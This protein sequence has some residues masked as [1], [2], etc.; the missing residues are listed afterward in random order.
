M[1]EIYETFGSLTGFDAED[2]T[3]RRE[4]TYVVVGTDDSGV[5]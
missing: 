2:N 4:K 5:V 1:A 3:G